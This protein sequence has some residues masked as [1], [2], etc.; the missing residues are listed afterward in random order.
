MP[1]LIEMLN[2]NKLTLITALAQNEPALAQAAVEG[3]TDALL[4]HVNVREFGDYISEKEK[5]KGVL[6]VVDVPVGVV[7]GHK[8][9]ATHAEI[10]EMVKMG[11]DFFNIKIEYAPRFV[12]DLKKVAK[13]MALGSRF[14]IDVVLG[15][16]RYGANAIDAAIIPSS[17]YG[18]ELMVGDLQN[19]ISIVMSAGI[20]VIV[21]TQRSI[22]SSEAAII[23]DTGAKGLMLTPI[24]TGKTAK[25]V[26]EKV[27][28]FRV[29]VDDIGE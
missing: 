13:V 26:K 27:Q 3:G 4:L 9:Q 16:G 17:E 8:E 28:E 15:V 2:A 14:T 7:T 25:G 21:P 18:K 29:A 11:V 12:P 23:A 19:Y 22:K 1:R 10:E 6:D 5:I 20:P 24:V